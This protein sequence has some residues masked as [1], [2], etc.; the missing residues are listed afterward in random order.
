MI[1]NAPKLDYSVFL[2]HD[3]RMFYDMFCIGYMQAQVP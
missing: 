2:A 3:W 1:I